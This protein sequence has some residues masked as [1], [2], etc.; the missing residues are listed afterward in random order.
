MN[1]ELIELLEKNAGEGNTPIRQAVTMLRQQQAEIEALK[2][3]NTWQV[4]CIAEQK[5]AYEKLWKEHMELFWKHE[6]DVDEEQE[7]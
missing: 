5:S 6:K 1:N 7:K 3:V 4:D 2:E